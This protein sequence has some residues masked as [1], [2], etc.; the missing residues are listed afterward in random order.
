MLTLLCQK[1]SF[2]L[3]PVNLRQV[4]QAKA[5]KEG[6]Q[7]RAGVGYSMTETALS[8]LSE[9]IRLAYVCA[10]TLQMKYFTHKFQSCRQEE[11]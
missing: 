11:V 7:S 2:K 3:P 1:F 6:R 4:P 5:T 9:K 10:A 8:Q